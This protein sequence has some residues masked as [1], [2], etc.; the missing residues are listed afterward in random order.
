MSLRIGMIIGLVLL[1]LVSAVVAAPRT[2]V[3]VTPIDTTAFKDLR[4]NR[5]FATAAACTVGNDSAISYY[6]DGWV[7]GAELYKAYID[8]SK[9]CSAPYPFT[10]TQINMPMQFKKPCTLT[11]SVDVEAV[12]N[13][14][15]NCHAPG[16]LKA[17]SSD[18]QLSVPAAGGYNIWIPLDTPFVVTGPFFA[19]FYLANALDTSVGAAVYCDNDPRTCY[20]YNIWDTTIGFIDLVNNTYYNFPGRLALYAIGLPGGQGEQPAPAVSLLRPN[21]GDVLF[22]STDLWAWE[23]SGSKIIDY[24]SF[25]YSKGAGYVEI[26]RDYDGLRPL[27]DGVNPADAGNGYSLNWDFSALTA[28]TYIIKATAVDTLGRTSSDSVTVTIEPTAPVAKIV[29]P[30]EGSD[31]CTPLS[32]LMQ[33]SDANLSSV[34]VYRTDANPNY[35]LGLT[36]LNQQTL[37]DV[38]GN[39][40]DGNHAS[41]GEFGDYYSGPA[42]AA[43]AVKVWA[44]RGYTSTMREGF[45][46]LTVSQL[47][48]RLATEFKTRLHKGTYDEDLYAGLKSY[49]QLRG[50]EFTFD[51]QRKP[52]Y[53]ALR[54]WLE[55]EQRSVVLGV[56]GTPGLWVAVNGFAGWA[57]ADGSWNVSIMN[58]LT[59]LMVETPM[60]M[61]LGVPE[62]SIGGVWH[63]IDIMVSMLAKTWTVTRPMIGADMNG[64]D[65]WSVSWTPTGL[66]EGN[67]YIF[68]AVGRDALSY[69]GASTYIGRYKCVGIYKPGDFNN[70]AQVDVLDLMMLIE[71]MAH[72]GQPPVGGAGRAD[73]NCD[74]NV[75]IADIVYF[76]NYLFGS[77]GAPCY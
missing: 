25:A 26:G 67:P 3:R 5:S 59:G 4:T 71:F 10:V 28:G 29:S 61:N 23:Q 50:D 64:A 22:A 53:Y 46:T 14:N 52:D 21:G 74:H 19:G 68:R 73:C 60:R 20:S 13:S 77:A 24:V 42:A 9:G 27:R 62:L 2:G 65:G 40:N 58:P 76:I 70:D 43:V 41:T 8:P 17:L 12:D 39:P 55:D 56:G 11:V 75:N 38:N 7:A 69:K 33:T 30:T 18:W 48:E 66:T 35:S 63:S 32:L 16:I 37:G 51:Y 15:P 36:L 57:A 6:I 34:T 49:Y 1:F 54:T 47:A 31:F 72:N 44:D 45:T